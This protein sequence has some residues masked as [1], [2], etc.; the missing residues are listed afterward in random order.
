MSFLKKALGECVYALYPTCFACW[1]A[2]RCFA[3]RLAWRPACRTAGL[4]TSRPAGRPAS[5]PAGLPACLPAGLPAGLP[6]SGQKKFNKI[7]NRSMDSSVLVS[8]HP[9]LDSISIPDLDLN[10][11][12]ESFRMP[13]LGRI[14]ERYFEGTLKVGHPGTS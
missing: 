13:F 2:R 9:T 7:S 1:Q 4:P 3:C 12:P 11:I 6:V 8:S 5:R 14:P 10:V